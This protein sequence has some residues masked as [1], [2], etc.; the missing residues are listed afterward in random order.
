MIE[1][2]NV[3]KTYSNGV[4]ANENISFCVRR[5]QAVG[6][7]GPNGSG[8]TTLIRQLL[9]ILSITHGSIIIDGTQDYLDKL[10]YVPQFAA[11]YPALTVEE[12]VCLALRYQKKEKKEAKRLARD[13]LKLTGLEEISGQHVYT[14]SGGQQKLL[15]FANA[16]AQEK[17]YLI[18]DEPTSM[19]DIVTKE[20]LWEIIGQTKK[21]RGILLASHDMEEIKR[22]CDY[23]VVLKNGRV[24]CQGSADSIGT[25]VC[26]CHISVEDPEKAL[27][28][29]GAFAKP[30]ADDMLKLTAE[31]VESCVEIIQAVLQVT[32]IKKL[33]CEFPAFYEGVIEIVK[34]N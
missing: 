5:G 17:P 3:S 31:N 6:L 8:K 13:I 20:R 10:S 29:A 34:D 21:N 23:V 26:T 28:A 24:V 11:A 2:R 7:V 25:G 27:C 18:L 22:L 1:F 32:G 12:T 19:V 14:L 30:T 33:S 16:L 15:A 9:K 4:V